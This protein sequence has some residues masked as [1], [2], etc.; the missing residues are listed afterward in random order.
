MKKI[1]LDLDGVIS[2]FMGSAMPHFGVNAELDAEVR[3][4][5]KIK[6]SDLIEKEIGTGRFWKTIDKLGEEWWAEMP[7]L[8]WGKDL[9]ELSVSLVGKKNVFFLTSPSNKHFS[10]SGKILFL[11]KHFRGTRQFILTPHKYLLATPDTL[12]V[13]D[14]PKKLNKFTEAGGQGLL[15]PQQYKLMDG[16]VSINYYYD[17]IKAFAK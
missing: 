2:D 14:T 12:L 16:D 3:E 13:D 9:F 11:Q 1:F 5:M 6:E 8:P 4:A 10:S 7:L 15:W 17:Q